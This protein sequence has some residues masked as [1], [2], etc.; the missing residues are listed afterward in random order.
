MCGGIFAVCWWCGLKTATDA[1]KDSRVLDYVERGQKMVLV[2]CGWRHTIC[3][4]SSVV[5]Y[6]YGWSKYGQLG[7]GDF[8]DHLIPH[9]L[10][11][12]RHYFISERIVQIS[13][14]WRHTLAA[15]ERKNIF[16]WG[17]GTNGQLGDGSSIDH[18]EVPHYAS[19]AFMHCYHEIP[20][21]Y[22]HQL[23]GQTPVPGQ[24]SVPVKGK[25]NDLS[26]PEN[27]VKRI[28]V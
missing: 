20:I 26:V 3:V 15:T 19:F 25:G 7:H 27:D 16:S 18:G 28:R 5:I 23:E 17:R 24:A 14:G 10:D 22:S 12:L 6:T 1:M 21:T 9:Q 8:E 2:A 4:S 13:C 11:A